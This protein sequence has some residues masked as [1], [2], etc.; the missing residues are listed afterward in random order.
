MKVSVEIEPGK[1]QEI[2]DRE[3]SDL[4]SRNIMTTFCESPRFW[5]VVDEEIIGYL[6]S[7]KFVQLIRKVIADSEESL[8]QAIKNRFLMK[9]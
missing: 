6:E 7:D 4:V 1:V 2:A 3:F 8:A 9:E 5:D